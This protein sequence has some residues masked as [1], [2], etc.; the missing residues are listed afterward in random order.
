MCFL[1]QDERLQAAI[2]QSPILLFNFYQF[3]DLALAESSHIRMSNM[4]KF[5]T[6]AFVSRQRIVCCG[7]PE[8]RLSQNQLEAIF[9][10]LNPE[11]DYSP[12]IARIYLTAPD[13]RPPTSVRPRLRD[14]DKAT[15]QVDA[16]GGQVRSTNEA[17]LPSGILNSDAGQD[18]SNGS[19]GS[20]LKAQ[21][22]IER[23]K[24][25]DTTL[26]VFSTK[27]WK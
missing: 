9:E 19:F 17:I 14:T 23:L 26:R 7:C 16:H 12:M 8:Q 6:K 2:E 10:H 22:E 18:H 24:K 15:K 25:E 20:A 1:C 13:G 3:Y 11:T 4:K 5:R 27:V 21:P